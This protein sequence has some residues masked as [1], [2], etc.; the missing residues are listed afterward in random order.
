MEQANTSL[1]HLSVYSEATLFDSNRS[2]QCCSHKV[3]RS[4][5]KC[6]GFR[7]I[8]K[9]QWRICCNP[10]IM[11]CKVVDSIVASPLALITENLAAPA[12]L[13]P[14]GRFDWKR[15]GRHLTNPRA[16]CQDRDLNCISQH[17]SVSGWQSPRP[18]IFCRLRCEQFSPQ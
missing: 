6:P 14:H 7:L 15:P 17:G 2:S 3:V 9:A 8:L 11:K 1:L 5:V 13:H 16:V 12:E 4:N 10:R 18:L